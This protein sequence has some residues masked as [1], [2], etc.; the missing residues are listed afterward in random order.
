MKRF[1]RKLLVTRKLQRPTSSV[2]L[3]VAMASTLIDGSD[4]LRKATTDLNHQY[5]KTNTGGLCRPVLTINSPEPVL[6]EAN[7][8]KQHE[9]GLLRRRRL[10]SSVLQSLLASR[11]C[12]IKASLSLLRQEV[13]QTF[14][15]S[16]SDG[17]RFSANLL[18]IA[19]DLRS[20]HTCAWRQAIASRVEA[21]ASRLEAMS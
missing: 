18:R 9:L 19:M 16:M 6:Q 11:S 8:V 3:L 15:D 13:H 1:P 20:K 2:L 5:E 4:S 14:Q 7:R 10:N 17:L 21:I 12:L